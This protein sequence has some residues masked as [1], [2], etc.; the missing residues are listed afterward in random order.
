MGDSA[1]TPSQ[2]KSAHVLTIFFHL[3]I[4]ALILYG[5]QENRVQIIQISAYVLIII[6]I[7][8]FIPILS[9]EYE[10]TPV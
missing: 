5:L 1:L 2:L 6:S 9:N 8:A 7:L 3:I 4:G 10:C